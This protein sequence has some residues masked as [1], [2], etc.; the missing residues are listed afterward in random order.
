[1]R[2]HALRVIGTCWWLGALEPFAHLRLRSWV[3]VLG[4]RSH[5]S[6]ESRRYSATLAALRMFHCW[7]ELELGIMLEGV[8]A[9][10]DNPFPRLVS[11]G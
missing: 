5:F 3:H 10:P 8:R 2:H 7:C 6:A 11:S 9:S 4:Y 1:M